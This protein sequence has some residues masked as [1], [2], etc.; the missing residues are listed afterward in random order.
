MENE[1]LVYRALYDFN[2][3]QLSIIAALE[4][5]AALIESMGQLA[6]QTSESL[7]RHLETVGNNCDRSCNAVYALAN[8]NY[9]P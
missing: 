8:L 3:T 5:M 1:E 7:R 9:A 6:P 2:L 4:D